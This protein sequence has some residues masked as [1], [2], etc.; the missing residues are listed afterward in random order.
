V[1]NLHPET[2]KI[3]AEEEGKPHG[4]FCIF[5]QNHFCPGVFLTV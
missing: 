3:D 5:M 1:K 2:V 4:A